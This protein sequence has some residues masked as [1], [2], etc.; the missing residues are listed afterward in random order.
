MK[1]KYLVAFIFDKVS[2]YKESGDEFVTLYDGKYD[3]IPSNIL[4]M[5]VRIIGAKRKGIIDIEV[6]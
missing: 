4:E 1:V 3:A 2:I 5:E 6:Y